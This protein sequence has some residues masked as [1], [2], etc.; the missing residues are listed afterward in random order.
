VPG[1]DA[2][3]V[4]PNDLLKSMGEK[5]KWDSDKQE[6][7]DALKHLQAV[8]KKYGVASGIHVADVEAARASP[9]G[10]VPIHRRGE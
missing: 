9:R 8:G 6:F 1:I 4:G 5:P 7:I 3:F 10:R 2:F